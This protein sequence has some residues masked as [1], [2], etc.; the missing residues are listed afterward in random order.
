MPELRY[1][2]RAPA[3]ADAASS[4]KSPL[5]NDPHTESSE[6]SSESEGDDANARRET[7]GVRREAYG[8]SRNPRVVRSG[9]MLAPGDASVLVMLPDHTRPGYSPGDTRGA[10]PR[11][12]PPK[13]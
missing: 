4:E 6:K 12:R 2:A 7:Y 9:E 11:E 3:L 5:L 13:R 1:E 10:R 8:A